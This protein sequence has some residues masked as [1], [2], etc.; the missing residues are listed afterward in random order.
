MIVVVG[1][2]VHCPGIA[3]IV[4]ILLDKAGLVDNFAEGAESIVVEDSS[5]EIEVVNSTLAEAYMQGTG[6][7]EASECRIG[8]QTLCAAFLS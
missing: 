1:M 4:Y 3:D 6:L 7:Q 8:V 5:S 2:T